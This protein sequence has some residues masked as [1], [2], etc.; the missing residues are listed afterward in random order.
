MCRGNVDHTRLSHWSSLGWEHRPR[1]EVVDGRKRPGLGIRR[2]DFGY[3]GSGARCRPTIENFFS[4][5]FS[6]IH[7]IT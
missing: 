5:D 3:A 4:P 6:C 7:A 2:R 1:H